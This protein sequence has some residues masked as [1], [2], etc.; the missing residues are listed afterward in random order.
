MDRRTGT[1]SHIDGLPLRIVQRG[2]NRTACFC[3][4]RD[5]RA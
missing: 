1:R 4:D 5:R 2:H 3:D